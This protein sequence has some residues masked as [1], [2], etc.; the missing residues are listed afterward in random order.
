MFASRIFFGIVAIAS[1]GAASPVGEAETAVLKRGGGGTGDSCG[2]G[3]NQQCC[4]T[5]GSQAENPDITSLL[6][7][8]GVVIQDINAV[9]GLN[10][11]PISVLGGGAGGCEQTAVCCDHA[12]FNGLINIGCIAL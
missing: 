12:Q 2:S 9:V 10:C 11:N 8:L 3:G 1:L 4:N 7:L 5:V 6:G